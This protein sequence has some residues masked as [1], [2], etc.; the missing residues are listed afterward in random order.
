ME[1][2]LTCSLRKDIAQFPVNDDGLK[3]LLSN[4]ACTPRAN[5][6]EAREQISSSK[7]QAAR[8]EDVEH[9][10]GTQPPVDEMASSLREE[11]AHKMPEVSKTAEKEQSP[12][13]Y[14]QQKVGQ[15]ESHPEAVDKETTAEDPVINAQ[16]TARHQ[17]DHS[18]ER[19]LCQ[20]E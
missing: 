18:A 9:T 8:N 17:Y 12:F 15:A 1:R 14:E 20:V 3:A 16:K 2:A 19:N 11:P 4:P 6:V 10:P 7:W 5:V 13:L